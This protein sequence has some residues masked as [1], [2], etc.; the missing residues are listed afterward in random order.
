MILRLGGNGFY[1][2]VIIRTEGDPNLDMKLRCL[3]HMHEIVLENNNSSFI[4]PARLIHRI[5]HKPL[6]NTVDPDQGPVVQSI[7]SLTSSL[8][9]QL[10][11]CFTTS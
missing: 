10:F 7:V 11:K 8:K 3:L 5:Y 9:G 6:T 4:A 2:R 1:R